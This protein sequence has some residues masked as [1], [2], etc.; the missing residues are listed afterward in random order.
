MDRGDLR[1]MPHPRRSAIVYHQ[2]KEEL[3]GNFGKPKVP[4]L[5][6]VMVG[7]LMSDPSISTEFVAGS[8]AIWIIPQENAGFG[9]DRATAPQLSLE[10]GSRDSDAIAI[11]TQSIDA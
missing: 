4:P 8:V 10:D 9:V 7:S 6:E 11:I 3:L 5:K 1:E 2:R